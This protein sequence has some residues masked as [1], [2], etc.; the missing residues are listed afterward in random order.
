[1]ENLAYLILLFHSF[2]IPA[3]LSAPGSGEYPNN[4]ITAGMNPA[5][6]VANFLSD[7]F[8][9]EDSIQHLYSSIDLE[10]YNLPY[11]VF[12]YGMIGYYSLKKDGKLSGKN[13]ISIIDFTKPSTAKRFYTIDLEHLKVLYHSYV[14]HGRNTGE[15]MAKSFSNI[16]Q[17]NQSSIGFY[18]TAETYV[19]SKGYSLKLDGMEKGF[20]DKIRERAVVM[21]E[22]DYVSEGWIKQ[23]GRL[24]RSQGCPALPKA[25]AHEVIDVI[26]GGTP[27]FA[28][29]DDE[30]YLRSSSCLDLNKVLSS[31][32][33]SARLNP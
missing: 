23:N 16:A 11:A 27:I 9:F 30:S 25:I 31:D 10:K 33:T 4:T 29:F 12:K 17:S 19:G 13:L 26:K 22:A 21:H 32:N 14:S 7:S 2:V 18:T 20:N 5:T 15:N 3:Q 28:Y 8:A 1:M 6:S 24:G